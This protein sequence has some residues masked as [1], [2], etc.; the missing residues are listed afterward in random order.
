MLKNREKK[1]YIICDEDTGFLY[2]R[3]FEPTTNSIFNINPENGYYSIVNIRNEKLVL[4][5]RNLIKFT[6]I[7]NIVTNEN[8]FKLDITYEILDK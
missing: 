3:E 2:D 7:K 4:F 6:D 8:L 5:N 1:T